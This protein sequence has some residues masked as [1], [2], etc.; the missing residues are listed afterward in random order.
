MSLLEGKAGQALL[1]LKGPN[2]AQEFLG[3]AGSSPSS[4]RIACPGQLDSVGSWGCPHSPTIN[5]IDI[6][7]NKVVQIDTAYIMT[8]NLGYLWCDK[9]YGYLFAWLLCHHKKQIMVAQRWHLFPLRE[10]LQ[11]Q[12]EKEEMKRWSYGSPW[13]HDSCPDI[14]SLYSCP[15][16][17]PQHPLQRLEE[18]RM[19]VGGKKHRWWWPCSLWGRETSIESPLCM[20]GECII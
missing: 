9:G 3:H 15:L 16:Q 18:A 1:E 6:C 5:L 19:G 8:T 12:R 14:F 20:D 10:F 11:D 2:S 4:P 7:C 17:T 13:G